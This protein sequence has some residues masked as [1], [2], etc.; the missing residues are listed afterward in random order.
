MIR[1]AVVDDDEIICEEIG[2]I[3]EKYDMKYE[4]D[5]RCDQFT[6]CEDFVE[7]SKDNDYK[8]VFLDIEFPTMNGLEL[9]TQIRECFKNFKMQIIFISA[10]QDYAMDLFNVQPF[11]FLIKPI[12]EETVF[13]CLSKFFIYY[14]ENNKRFEYT[15]ENIKYCISINEIMYFES[16]G[17]KVIM[18]TLTKK[19]EFY[20]VF[21]ELAE[22]LKQQFVVIK[23]GLMVNLQY[24]INSNYTSIELS[25][26]VVLQISKNNRKNVRN[27]LC[28]Q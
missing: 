25:N 23:R 1:I 4:Y 22:Q 11:Q 10:K 5:I 3:V 16:K 27:R 7:K 2:R 28:G 13:S 6:S 26:N 17:K 24:V 15:F 21:S 12:N 19:I 20:A 14:L 8:L 9:S 18:H